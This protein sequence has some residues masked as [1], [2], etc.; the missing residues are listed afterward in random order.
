LAVV[1]IKTSV[2]GITRN[3]LIEM[4]GKAS[5]SGLTG[6]DRVLRVTLF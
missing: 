2:G 1:K 4:V 3:I 5:V 6:R